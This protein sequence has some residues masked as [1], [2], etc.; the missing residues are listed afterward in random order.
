MKSTLIIIRGN[1]GSGKTVLAQRL[2]NHFGTDNCLLLQQDVLR[3]NILHTN[4]HAGN[5]A[6]DLISDLAEFG[7]K[8]Y[9]ITILEGILR[10]D[11]Y[12]DMLT[13]LC[14]TFFPN[15]LIYYLDIP[16]EVTLRN[17]NQKETP[18]STTQLRNWWRERDY[19][20]NDTKFSDI[21]TSAM[22]EQIIND[23]EQLKK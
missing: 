20:P 10:K 8:H 14:K 6:I 3:R 22:L 21:G 13:E 7:Q 9:P 17:N 12:G 16:F 15:I 4:D 23:F 5:P 1:S 18:F 11:V 2:Q 19:L